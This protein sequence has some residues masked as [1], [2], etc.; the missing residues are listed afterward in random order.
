MIHC[1]SLRSRRSYRRSPAWLPPSR[2]PGNRRGHIAFLVEVGSQDATG[3]ALSVELLTERLGEGIPF[4]LRSSEGRRRDLMQGSVAISLLAAAVALPTHAAEPHKTLMEWARETR[5]ARLKG[6]Y[7]AWLDAGLHSLALAPDHP[8]L[9]I[10][11]ARARAGLG[12]AKESLEL[13]RQAIDRGAGIDIPRVQE[14][15]KLPTSPELDVLVARARKNLEPV[16]R[17]Q[18]FALIP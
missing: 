7:R 2:P 18:L 6:D 17:G 16:P 13:L 14:F 9:L 4:L 12:Q 11:V 8:D 3:G 1:S 10:S 5:A 15:Q